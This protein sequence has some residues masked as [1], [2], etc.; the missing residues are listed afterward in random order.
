MCSICVV[1]NRLYVLINTT[2]RSKEP[3]YRQLSP[4]FLGPVELYGGIVSKTMENAWQYCK[5]YP[6]HVDEKGEPTQSY[7]DWARQGWEN[8]KANRFPMGRGVKPLY[9]LWDG[10]KLGYIEARIAIY[11]PLYRNAV[12]KTD[13]YKDLEKKVKDEIPLG[14]IDFDGWDHIGQGFTLD[15]VILLPKPKMGH[16]F[17]LASL[18]THHVFK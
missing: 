7:W 17:V 4:F 11:D 12:V 10:K 8:E 1:K 18:L 6:C 3:L 9:S 14:L 2:S 16:A 15:E 13:A 5:V